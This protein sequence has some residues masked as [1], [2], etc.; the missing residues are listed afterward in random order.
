M[1]IIVGN[2]GDAISGIA[3]GVQS[4]AGSASSA[5]AGAVT[6][7]IGGVFGSLLDEVL[8]A[9]GKLLLFFITFSLRGEHN[10]IDNSGSAQIISQIQGSLFWI[11]A[12]FITI[13][14][15][16]HAIR[17]IWNK[18]GAPLAELIKSI[19]V[20]IFVSTAGVALVKSGALVS[21]ELTDQF[22]GDAGSNAEYV[23]GGM[24]GVGGA[25][26]VAFSAFGSTFGLLLGIIW[27]I[28]VFLGLLAQIFII[29]LQEVMVVVASGALV[30]AASGQFFNFSKDW[31]DKIIGTLIGALLYKPFLALSMNICLTFM[32]NGGIMGFLGGGI[33][34]LLTA[35][36]FGPVLKFF[37]KMNYS[38]GIGSGS[39]MGTGAANGRSGAN[40]PAA[41]RG[42]QY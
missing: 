1:I 38:G 32:A 17:I 19:V 27:G 8:W 24:L 37:K 26:V 36:G 7:A 35:W 22:I 6:G 30:L 13:G 31:L 18:S 29:Y 9:T 34:I 10:L 33:G 2:A 5:V 21:D 16:W 14:I 11:S 4:I 25:A 15:F 3:G 39:A 23:S 42:A 28:L 12:A 40:L 20:F 41:P